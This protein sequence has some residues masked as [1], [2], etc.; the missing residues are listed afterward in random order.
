M[1][2]FFSAGCHLASPR[3]PHR[4]PPRDDL[5][6]ASGARQQDPDATSSYADQSSLATACPL[7]T[8]VAFLGASLRDPAGIGSVTPSG[9]HLVRALVAPVEER[10]HLPISVLEVGAGTGPVTRSL[11]EMLGPGSHLDIVEVN[12]YFLPK[13]EALTS[14]DTQATATVHGCRIEDLKVSRRYDVIISSLPF[15]NMDPDSVTAI[16]ERY[17]S[18]SNPGA[19]ITWFA[20]RGSRR[21]RRLTAPSADVL[22]HSKV[23]DLLAQEGGSRRTVWANVP[24]AEVTR[25]HSPAESTSPGTSWRADHAA[26]RT[27]PLSEA[28]P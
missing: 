17:R 6:P 5:R 21:A 16:L 15:T 11:I 13:L 1:S 9:R 14:A 22:R 3:P 12:P 7:P 18:L 28:T 2:H 26:S 8:S 4:R 19:T 27:A 20:Y 23:E 24:P 25:I 10:V